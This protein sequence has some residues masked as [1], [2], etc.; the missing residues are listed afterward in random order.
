MLVDLLIDVQK[1]LRLKKSHKCS[2]KMKFSL[3][4]CGNVTD[5]IKMVFEFLFLNAE[6]PL[7]TF[8]LKTTQHVQCGMCNEEPESSFT[9]LTIPCV[10]G[11]S[12]D[13][14]RRKLHFHDNRAE[15][16][17]EKHFLKMVVRLPF[18]SRTVKIWRLT[19]IFRYPVDVGNRDLM[20]GTRGPFPKRLT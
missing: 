10:A 3:L 17:S 20:F 11:F 9:V 4:R 7:R 16:V 1:G 2:R 8:Q 5:N 6:I 18:K 19:T 13:D 12:L 15:S 14:H